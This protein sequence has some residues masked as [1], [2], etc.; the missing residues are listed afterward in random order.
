[1]F[2]QHEKARGGKKKNRPPYIFWKKKRKK[3]RS[4]AGKKR[5]RSGCPLARK[6]GR[7]RSR[8]LEKGGEGRKPLS[9]EKKRGRGRL[10]LAR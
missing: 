6:E 3:V 1:V 4:N 10:S 5:T 8:R 2:A 7:K 9:V